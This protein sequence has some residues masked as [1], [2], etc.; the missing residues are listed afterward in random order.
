M[1]DSELVECESC[2][3]EGLPERIGET[4]CPHTGSGGVERVVERLERLACVAAVDVVPASVDPSGRRTVEVVVVGSTVPAHVLDVV[5]DA[6]MAVRPE[7]SGV[8]G[9]PVHSVVVAET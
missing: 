5:A 3:R 9:E 4:E 2:G 7:A 1:S 6:G 8:R